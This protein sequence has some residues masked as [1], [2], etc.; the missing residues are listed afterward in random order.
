[1]AKASN[2]LGERYVLRAS[3]F[4]LIFLPII[5]PDGVINMVKKSIIISGVCQLLLYHFAIRAAQLGHLV[6]KVP[7]LKQQDSNYTY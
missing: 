7:F 5:N 1:M 4:I 6:F 3:Y 2:T